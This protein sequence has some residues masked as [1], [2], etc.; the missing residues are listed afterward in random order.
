MFFVGYL[1]ILAIDRVAAKA[2]HAGHNHAD[3]KEGKP[4]NANMMGSSVF[5][6]EDG[7]QRQSVQMASISDS[8]KPDPFTPAI[9]GGDTGAPQ[10]ANR[11][12]PGEAEAV[13]TN[14]TVS[15]T[16][17]IILVLALGAHAFF[18]GIAFGLQTT[19][20]SAG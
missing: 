17:A 3:G 13:K 1:L 6:N 18:E 16:A 9:G 15:K 5:Q 19:V 8:G 20:E 4:M 2:Y 11:V 10:A 7:T 12:A 14:T